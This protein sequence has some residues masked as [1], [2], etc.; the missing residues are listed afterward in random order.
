M[1]KRK[2]EGLLPYLITAVI[3]VYPFFSG[4]INQESNFYFALILF[5]I[6]LLFL[7]TKE[8][9]QIFNNR[10]ISF[11][12]LFFLISLFSIAFSVYSNN[13]LREAFSYL[14]YL[15]IF[16]LI[17]FSF[18]KKDTERILF[19]LILS[20]VIISIYGIYQYFI[21]F[22]R[23]LKY[24]LEN[25]EK[26]INI[27]YVITTLKEKRIF[28]TT[29]SPDMLGGYLIMMIP[30]TFGA[31]IAAFTNDVDMIKKE[32]L[33]KRTV[34]YLILAII[35]LFIALILTRSI[36]AW[37][38]FFLVFIPFSYLMIKGIENE[39]MKRLFLYAA[40]ITILSSAVFLS[41]IIIK[42][43]K[44]QNL[45]N[46]FPQSIKQRTENWRSSVEII[47]DF[48]VTGVGIG[49]FGIIYPKYKL[50]NANET[51][52]AHNNYL[53]LAAEAGVVG[54]II[55]LCIILELYKIS[56][57]YL[58]QN[59]DY[60]SLGL[61][62]A[63][64]AFLMHSFIDFDFFIPE[65]A[66]HWWVI[67]GLL[68]ARMQTIPQEVKLNK[69]IKAVLLSL[70]LFLSFFAAKYLIADSFFNMGIQRLSENNLSE[71]NFYIRK[72]IKFDSKNDFYHLTLA[73]AIE[74]G[75]S[76]EE[77]KTE[78]ISEIIGHY[79]KAIFLNPFYSYHH[80]DLGLFY[81]QIGRADMAAEEF[82]KA[83]ELYPTNPVYPTLGIQNFVR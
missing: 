39:R 79:N 81:M 12:G 22:E 77:N 49:S 13:S 64:S 43:S 80:R 44:D 68:T 14:S 59:R 19:A 63:V 3:F 69:N 41:S 56:Y 28:S 58:K 15:L 4:K 45:P 16:I 32:E 60:I 2:I 36:G 21:G 35:V 51:K 74:K 71:G 38:S 10:L 48:P 47:K 29:F 34:S 82:K 26:I 70:L 8:A 40:V 30:I 54:L 1:K 7:Y 5:F 20:S 27:N 66:F 52:Y 42:R 53:Q 24:V 17:I 37:L 61:L 65:V 76:G 57:N 83:I 25:P 23:T 9:I 67:I 18:S 78:L 62:A 6:F 75:V 33:R 50:P 72:S 55:F 31:L 73:R 11:I 46:Y